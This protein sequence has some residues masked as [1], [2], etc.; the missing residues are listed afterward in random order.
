MTAAMPS[1]SAT[2]HAWSGPAPPNATSASP[3][4]VDAAFRPSPPAPPA[5]SPRRRPRRHRRPTRR[6]GRGHASAA[7][8]S[9]RPSP[10]S[11][12]AGIRPRTRSASVTVG[13]TPHGRN[14]P[15]RVRRRRSRGRRRARPRRRA[16]RS[17]PRPRRSCG[18]RATGSRTGRPPTSCI[19]AGS[20]TPPRIRQHVRAR[21]AHVER[22]RVRES[23]RDATTAAARTPPAGPDRSSAA[24]SSAATRR[25]PDRRPRSSRAPVGERAEPNRYGRHRGRSA[26]FTTVVTIRSYSRNSGE[27]SCE[28]VTSRPRRTSTRHGPLVSGVEVG[29]Q[30]AHCDRVDVGGQRRDVIVA[31]RL[32][33][34]TARVEPSTDLE[35][36]LTRHERRRPV[37]ER[38]VQ[39]RAGPGGRSR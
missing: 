30:Q 22:D 29:V 13:A 20:G 33:L 39:R 7:P 37:D 14:R 38:V 32:D 9:R 21:P 8:T 24:G 11:V 2:A 26:A 17:T 5:P 6:R 4:G 34:A 27:T 12:P 15:D 23:A 10:G 25:A 16:R 1:A 19:G 35:A 3:R 31:D 36:Q 18:C 28:H